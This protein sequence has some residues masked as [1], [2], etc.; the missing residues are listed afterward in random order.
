MTTSC[1]ISGSVC[2]TD[3][4]SMLFSSFMIH[5]KPWTCK[6][7]S[8]FDCTVLSN[9]KTWLTQDMFFGIFVDVGWQII[10][11]QGPLSVVQ[12]ELSTIC[13][14]LPATSSWKK[15]LNALSAWKTTK[16]AFTIG[17]KLCLM[18]NLSSFYTSKLLLVHDKQIH[19]NGMSTLVSLYL[20]R[21]MTID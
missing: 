10:P 11:G 20:T 16:Q 12:P 19:H 21:I 14:W 5:K 7:Q 3:H 2:N 13:A 18:Q 6:S 9:G 15:N 4:I 1:M 8:D 17:L